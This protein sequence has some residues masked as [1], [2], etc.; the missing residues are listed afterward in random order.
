M[1]CEHNPPGRVYTQVLLA[2][3]RYDLIVTEIIRLG[4]HVLSRAESV[5]G[6]WENSDFLESFPASSSVSGGGWHLYLGF[7]AQW[8]RSN[9]EETPGIVF[10]QDEMMA[11]RAP[12]SR[13]GRKFGK[14]VC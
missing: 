14:A 1:G 5:P 9:E 3:F 7:A 13:G 12:W 4:A 11:A 8:P 6:A 2:T 10:G